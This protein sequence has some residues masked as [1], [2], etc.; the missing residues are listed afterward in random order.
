[1]ERWLKLEQWWGRCLAPEIC[2][3]VPYGSRIDVWSLGTVL[4][5]LLVLKHPFQ[6][7]NMA[8]TVLKIISS[9][10]APLPTRCSQEVNQI[11][12]LCLQKDPSRRPSAKE[13]LA[14]PAVKGFGE[15][16]ARLEST[17]SDLGSTWGP[18]VEEDGE[19]SATLDGGQTR[20]YKGEFCIADPDGDRSLKAE[21]CVAQ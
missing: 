1:M 8:A 11:V 16:T 4:Y 13:L 15:E 3:N 12:Q 14:H 5:E 2:Q 20:L 10:P 6:S 18:I 19:E 21:G 7:S 17:S 9:E